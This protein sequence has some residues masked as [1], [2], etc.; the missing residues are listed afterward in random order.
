M[1]AMTIRKLSP[2]T[3]RKLK[4]MAVR[5]GHSTEAEVRRLLDAAVAGPEGRINMGK[6][7]AELGRKW[8]HPDL[9]IKRDQTLAG[10]TVSFD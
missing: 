6:V 4:L 10:S 1:S 8:G 9:D 2:E 7:L 3:H 5:N